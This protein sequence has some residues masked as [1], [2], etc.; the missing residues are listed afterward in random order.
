[1]IGRFSSLLAGHVDLGGM[2]QDATPANAR[3]DSDEHLMTVF[4]KTEAI[5]TCMDR[6][7]YDT[8]WL[9]EHHFQHEG[10]ERIPNILTAAVHLAHVT[11]RSFR[12]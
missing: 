2:G 7:G 4:S 5:A 12:S 10:Y 8:R 1:M 9:A 3:R 6:L 11:E